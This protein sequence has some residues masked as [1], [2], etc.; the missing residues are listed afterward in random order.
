MTTS[1]LT[2]EEIKA[3]GLIAHA[4]AL[5]S[6]KASFYGASRIRVGAHSRIDDF[7]V[8]SAGKGGIEIGRYVHIG[9]ASTLIG[10]GA[11]TMADFST[12]SGRVSVYS[13]SDDYSGAHMTN[14]TVPA[15]CKAVDERA[16]AI[17]RHVIIGAGSVILPGSTLAEGAAVGALSFVSNDVPAWTIVAG[18]PARPLRARSRGLLQFESTLLEGDA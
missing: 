18:R 11:I 12:L 4:T 5:I 6:R 10:D 9:V 13:S 16:V 1:F 14:P 8:L 17:E 3:T 15:A 7:C 2:P